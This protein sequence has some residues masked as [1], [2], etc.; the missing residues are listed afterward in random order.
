MRDPIDRF[1]SHYNH[2]RQ[3]NIHQMSLQE[4]INILGEHDYQTKFI[5][6]CLDLKDRNFSADRRHLEKA[7]N[8][9]FNDF[10]FVGLLEN[11]DES[12]ILLKHSLNLKEF[13]IRYQRMNVG[14]KR[15]I[16]K[17]ELSNNL[18]KK[19]SNINRIDFELYHLVREKLFEMKKREY[20]KNIEEAISSFR[21]KNANYRFKRSQIVKFN[22]ANY[23]V[24]KP[25]LRLWN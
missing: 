7:K 15:Y 11:F 16:I 8:I 6:G 21:L 20:G 5:L 24:Y 14:K 22:I 17:D 12:L 4:R 1:I 10:A 23:L 13:N 18:L 2:G 3:R 19:L 25:I 9:L